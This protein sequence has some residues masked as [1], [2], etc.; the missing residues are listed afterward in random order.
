MTPGDTGNRPSAASALD[1]TSASTASDAGA[2]VPDTLPMAHPE[3]SSAAAARP[4]RRRWPV[5]LATWSTGLA[6]V[7]GVSYLA[8]VEMRSSVLQARFFADWAARLGHEPKPQPATGSHYPK[9]GPSDERMGYTRLPDFLTSLTGRG[10][11]VVSQAQ[12]SAALQD[13]M[14]RGFFPP[15]PEKVQS[16]LTLKDCRGEPL[17]RS[18]FPIATYER[19]QDMPALVAQTLGFIENREVLDTSEPRHNPAIEWTRLGKAVLDQAVAVAHEDHAAAGGSTLATQTEKFRHSPDGRTSSARDKYLQMVSATVRAY[20]DGEN[21][22]AARRRILQDYLNSL[23]LG[24]QKGWGEVHGVNDGLAAWYGVDV[25]VANRRLREPGEQEAGLAARGLAFRQ[26]LSLMIA[27]RRPAHYFG[28]GHTQL[29][30]M[31]A[32]YTRLLAQEGI[33]GPA[34]RDAALAAPLD[35]RSAYTGPAAGI[36][37][38]ERN[39]S[40][41]LRVQLAS[42]LNTPRLYE[43]DRFDLSA[44]SHLDGHLQRDVTNL[45]N[46][47]RD[48]QVAKEAGLLGFQLL[49]KGDPSKLL[50]SFTLYERGEGVNRVRVQT[51]NLDQPFDINGS[52][53]LELG[54]TAKLRTLTT[55]LELIAKLH[56]D[57]VALDAKALSAV[58][59]G[60]KDRLSR[61]AV[62]WL[63]T[64]KDRSL[65]AMLEAAMLRKYSASPGESFFTGGGAHVFSNFNAS[66]N[67]RMATLY[68]SLRD[69]LNLPFIRLMRDIVYHHLYNAANPAADILEDEDH[70]RRLELLK[71]FINKEGRQFMRK[72][73]QRHHDKPV[74]TVLQ[75]MAAA[76][77]KTAPRLAVVYRSVHPDGTFEDFSAYLVRQMP[78]TPLP[79]DYLRKLYDRHAPGNYSLADR[80]Y[81][82][83]LHPLELWVANYLRQNPKAT[84]DQVLDAGAVEREESYNWLLRNKARRGQNSRIVQLLEIEA[85]AKIHAQW[86]RVGF[87]FDTLVPSY[88]T[89][90]GSSG[91]RPAALAE[92]MGIL[93]NDGKRLPATMLDTL[94]FA[95][96]SP[97][98]VALKKKPAEGEQVLAPETAAT[99]RK[100]LALVVSDGTARRI[101]G[102][103]DEPGQAP[104]VIGGK[105]G[106][107]D[108]RLNTYTRGG[109]LLAS[110]VTSRTATFVFYLGPR[111]FGTLTA[112]VLG[113]EAGSYKFTSALPTQILKN[114]APLLKPVLSGVSAQACPAGA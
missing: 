110:K 73:Y 104:M 43:L 69:S 49:E 35:V 14:A 8:H 100:A 31:T 112:F 40:T 46:R 90:I 42:M 39:A 5:T 88:A 97:Y 2:D 95:V 47:L 86:K 20:R 98:E 101:K 37:F 106:T 105:T 9:A 3:E 19:E 28:P 41:L 91:D 83:R 44:N 16:G 109:G 111:H 92:L 94:Q 53:K 57:Y 26:V 54:S 107:G 108:N 25:E 77:S 58:E 114:M 87:P 55:Y 4:P 113:P 48:P 79:S 72:F 78:G 34:L 18:R 62:D 23:P 17:F 12:Q 74:E 6:V 67:W 24:A 36:E 22:V 38:G 82:A 102:V 15:Y 103:L 51:D 96:G 64:A 50:Y 61:W 11:Q 27:Q 71:L 85:F 59:V 93:V 60:P 52:A 29:L 33:I 10:Y 13:F 66:D 45:L 99:L 32:S 68:E 89:A 75:T 84:L 65:A 81:L 76:V 63:L 21:T 70:P 1:A 80:G 30:N 7:A 56:Q